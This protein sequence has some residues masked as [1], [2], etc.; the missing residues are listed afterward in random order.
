MNT[1]TLTKGWDSKLGVVECTA[2]GNDWIEIDRRE[3]DQQLNVPE[4]IVEFDVQKVVEARM[5]RIRQ[6]GLNWQGN[7]HFLFR[8][9]ELY[10]GL[11]IPP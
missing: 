9:F 2:R 7:N 11:R 5:V 1:E 10:G 4:A 3:N 6:T 8:G